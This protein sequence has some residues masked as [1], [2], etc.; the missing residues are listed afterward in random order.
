MN[1]KY[2][3]SENVTKKGV[4]HSKQTY[5][6][7]DCGI[8]L[9]LYEPTK[10]MKDAVFEAGYYESPVWGQKYPRIQILTIPELLSGNKPEIPHTH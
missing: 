9:T 10:P 6:C 2:C 5:R 1:C 4:R 3:N 8:L 7:K